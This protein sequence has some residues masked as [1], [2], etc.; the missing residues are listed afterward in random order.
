MVE[1][2]CETIVI[3]PVVGLFHLVP[4]NIPL[5][6]MLEWTRNTLVITIFKVCL[7]GH[8]SIIFIN[9]LRIVMKLI[10]FGIVSV[11][12]PLTRTTTRDILIYLFRSIIIQLLVH[13]VLRG[14]LRLCP[15]ALGTNCRQ[16][17][18]SLLLRIE[19]LVD[20]QLDVVGAVA[21]DLLHQLVL[22]CLIIVFILIN[23]FLSI[24]VVAVRALLQL[25][26]RLLER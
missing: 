23:V 18:M 13:G 2:S 12:G 24:V 22:L 8:P 4:V 19:L 11:G 3:S 14:L 21:K 25:L 20:W 16:I 26:L 9:K 5:S 6:K 15:Q 1:V 10:L 7:G 17:I